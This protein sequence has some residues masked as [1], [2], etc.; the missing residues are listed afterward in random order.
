[1][2]LW[3]IL[4]A[5]VL[6]GAALA[7]GVVD[8]APLSYP[9]VFLTLGLLL[10]AGGLR[11]VT[12]DIHA[13]VLDA[14]AAISLS[15]VL[16]LDA[17]KL[18]VPELRR[19]WRVPFLTLG[20]G[21]ILVVVGIALTAHSFFGA[22]WG[23]AFL[24]GAALASTDA[25]VMRDITRNERVPRS[26]RRALT[27]ESGMNDI[28]VLPIILIL[29]AVN[30]STISGFGGWVR[31][32]AQLLILSP[33]LG[34]VVGGVG[35]YLMGKADARLSIRREY[36]ALY[37][38][39]L[40]LAAYSL[41]QAVGADGFLAAFF[42]GLAVNIFDV[43][44][45][46]CFLEYGE[47]S[48]EMLMLFTFLLFGIVLSGLFGTIA[49]LPAFAF[50]LIVIVVIRPVAL[51]LVYLRARMS[52]IARAFIGWFGPR[53]LSTLLLMLLVVQAGLPL[54]V[55]LFAVAGVVVFVSV[56]LHGV[57]ATP[58]SEWYGRQVAASVETPPEEREAGAGGLFEP[59]ANAIPRITPQELARRLSGPNPPVVLDVRTRGRYATDDGQIPD[60]VRIY[61]DQVREWAADA[62]RKRSVVAYCT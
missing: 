49:L 62:D 50:A 2:L 25:I 22:E 14:V 4:I 19:D 44:L 36:Q 3:F 20:P 37:G 46:D 61:P 23:P 39:G 26:V 55:Q 6:L 18:D 31:F 43:S 34:L 51:G 45:C 21:T 47:I 60:S 27:I 7:S 11:L 32:L 24:L 29:I 53:G 1:M 54:A 42:A 59:E 17:A 10:G 8:R 56:I 33:L 57:S 48:A 40:V 38:L 15:L 35:A 41:A 12:L 30:Q 28:V 9:M 58:L 16:F 52:W 5:L 13:P